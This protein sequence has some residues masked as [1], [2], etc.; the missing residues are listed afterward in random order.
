M[1]AASNMNGSA[2]IVP[3]RISVPGFGYPGFHV[4][5]L[6]RKILRQEPVP[7][8]RDDD[9]VLDAHPEAL[10]GKV[11]ARLDGEHR[12]DGQWF[13]VQAGIMHVQPD[14]VSKSVDEIL[15]V[16]GAAQ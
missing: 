16:A 13:F 2:G 5:E 14:E 7:C 6:A 10:L 3:P 12:A 8:G 15:E 4:L 9:F 11:D 1:T